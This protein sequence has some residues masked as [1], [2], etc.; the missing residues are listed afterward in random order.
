MFFFAEVKDEIPSVNAVL[1]GALLDLG[2]PQSSSNDRSGMKYFLGGLPIAGLNLRVHSAVL[3]GG[4]AAALLPSPDPAE[5]CAKV[6]LDAI[7]SLKRINLYVVGS[8]EHQPISWIVDAEHG[9]PSLRRVSAE[10]GRAWRKAQEATTEFT[11]SS[12]VAPTAVTATP[13]ANE[14]SLLPPSSSPSPTTSRPPSGPSEASIYVQLPGS[15]ATRRATQRKATATTSASP[16]TSVSRVR[17]F[18]LLPSSV[19]PSSRRPP[20][21]F[22]PTPPPTTSIAAD[23]AATPV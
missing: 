7:P 8:D 6:L 12:S 4:M 17:L 10:E 15:A 2:L 13:T 16:L 14:R 3:N 9:E 19:A 21:A 23:G 1:W 11:H 22:A 20:L 18:L 5:A